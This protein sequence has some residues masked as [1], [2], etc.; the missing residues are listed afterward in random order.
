MTY[1]Q[2]LAMNDIQ[3]EVGTM[4]ICRTCGGAKP[5]SGFKSP[6]GHTCRLCLTLGRSLVR[7]A[8]SFQLVRDKR[9]SKWLSGARDR[10][11]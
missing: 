6:E 1:P 2:D 9:E 11:S 3:T 5:L 10:T 4:R 7:K 8:L